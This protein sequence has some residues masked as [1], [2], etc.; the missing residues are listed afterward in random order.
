[1]STRTWHRGMLFR[2]ILRLRWH[3][4]DFRVG[5]G[6]RIRTWHWGMSFRFILLLGRHQQEFSVGDGA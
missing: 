6:M 2:F 5:G 1:M 4:Q 3:H